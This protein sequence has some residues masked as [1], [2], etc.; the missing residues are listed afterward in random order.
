MARRKIRRLPVVNATPDGAQLLGIVTHS[1][2]LHAFPA[3]INPFAAIAADSIVPSRA[4]A[5]RR[6][7]TRRISWRA[8]RWSRRRMRRSNLPRG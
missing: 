6:G 1:D 5:D 8:I 2:V 3:D 7:F 4:A